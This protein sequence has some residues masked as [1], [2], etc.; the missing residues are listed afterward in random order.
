MSAFVQSNSGEKNRY[1]ELYRA[2]N[3]SYSVAE[4]FSGGKTICEVEVNDLEKYNNLY[5]ILQ[6]TDNYKVHSRIIPVSDLADYNDTTLLTSEG[7]LMLNLTGN[8][9]KLYNGSTSAND[10]IYCYGRTD[11]DEHIGTIFFL[12]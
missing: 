11:Q 3:A 9:L 2:N 1:L 6:T 7:K 12:A 4:Q 5:L 8:I 10:I